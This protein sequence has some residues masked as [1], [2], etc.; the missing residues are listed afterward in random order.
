M[1]ARHPPALH[2]RARRVAPQGSGGAAT[3]G[4]RGLTLM[5]V[6]VAIAIMLLLTAA[7]MPSL[8]AVFMLEQRAAARRMALAFEKMHDE[9]V[10]RNRTYRFWFDLDANTWGI[11]GGDAQFLI[12]DDPEARERWEE[13]LGDKLDDMDEQ[14]KR[15]FLK[16]REFSAVEGEY[17]KI[18]MPRGARIHSVYTP[19]YE[20]PVTLDSR[21]RTPVRTGDEKEPL[22]AFS[23]LFSNGFAEYTVIQIVETDDEDSGFTITVDPLSGKVVLHSD[24][25]DHHDAFRFLPD[26]GPRLNL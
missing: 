26:E 22:R 14:E 13:N 25:I 7:L 12:F 23:H 5:E 24:L 1:A 3:R 16:E 21:R 11:E 6:L 10:L 20:D 18:T 17:A 8:N 9:A 15:E 2:R 4:R 19:Q